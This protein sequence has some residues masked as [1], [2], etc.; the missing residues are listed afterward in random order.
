MRMVRYFSASGA[1]DQMAPQPSQ[2]AVLPPCAPPQ[3][4]VGPLQSSGDPSSVPTGPPVAVPSA[5]DVASMSSSSL[6][7]TSSSVISVTSP[8]ANLTMLSRTATVVSNSALSDPSPFTS[9]LPLVSSSVVTPSLPTS[10]AG[11]SAPPAVDQ[12]VDLLAT[13]INKSIGE[14]SMEADEEVLDFGSGGAIVDEV[15]QV[16]ANSVPAVPVTSFA[17]SS[18]P[19]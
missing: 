12:D 16:V 8:T 1:L 14:V 3:H 5:P 15:R 4:P 6:Q 7:D 18:A 19:G 9:T 2:P 11:K 17:P 10:M 13:A